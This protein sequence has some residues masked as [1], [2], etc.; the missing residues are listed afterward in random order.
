MPLYLPVATPAT[1]LQ[2]SSNRVQ[3][4]LGLNASMIPYLHAC[5]APTELTSIFPRH[6]TYIELPDLRG[7]IHPWLHTSTSLHLQRVSINPYLYASTCMHLQCASRA[8]AL[9]TS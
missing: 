7:S 2:S 1:C 5:S 4:W 9:Y 3:L 6:Y 8:P